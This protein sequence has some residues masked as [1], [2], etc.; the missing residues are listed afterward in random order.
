MPYIRSNEIAIEFKGVI[1]TYKDISNTFNNKHNLGVS[2]MSFAGSWSLI[3]TP[4]EMHVC[5]K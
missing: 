4:Q 3:I 5:I 1:C 2:Q